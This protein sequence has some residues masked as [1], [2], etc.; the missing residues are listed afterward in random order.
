MRCAQ[1][2]APA[3]PPA[4]S[5]YLAWLAQFLQH[6]YLSFFSLSCTDCPDLGSRAA[7]PLTLSSHVCTYNRLYSFIERSRHLRWST[8]TADDLMAQLGALSSRSPL[9]TAPRLHSRRIVRCRAEKQPDSCPEC[10]PWGHQADGAASTS[11]SAQQRSRP[12]WNADA[13]MPGW[14]KKSELYVLR[15]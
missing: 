14:P 1:A 5:A 15:R 9:L 11:A 6:Q 3:A 8:G 2:P 12:D 13:G 10:T 7:E 4:L